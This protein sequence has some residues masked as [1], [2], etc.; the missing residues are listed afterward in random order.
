MFQVNPP[1]RGQE[2]DAEFEEYHHWGGTTMGLTDEAE[3]AMIACDALGSIHCANPSARRELAARRG[4]KIVGNMVR[5]ASGCSLELRSALIDAAV[6]H[7]RQ[8]VTVGSDA[9]RF[10][11]RLVPLCD[12]DAQ[13]SVL[14]MFGPRR[15]AP[16][17]HKWLSQSPT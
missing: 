6:R 4:L 13:A 7:R 17:W 8:C 14:I 2:S 3:F 9:A 10:E 15:Q 11:V 12:A 16:R 1:I 5:C